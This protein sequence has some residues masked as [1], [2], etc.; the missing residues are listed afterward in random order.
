MPISSQRLSSY[1]FGPRFKT[2][3]ARSRY[4][5]R[6]A[7]SIGQPECGIQD[8][9]SKTIE[10]N[11]AD[12]PAQVWVEPRSVRH[13]TTLGCRSGDHEERLPPRKAMHNLLCVLVSG[14]GMLVT[15]RIVWRTRVAS[16]K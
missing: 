15:L 12:F 10:S 9:F 8:R 4:G 13:R 3:A 2:P 14:V 5:A 6:L 1:E 11:A 16:S 7:R